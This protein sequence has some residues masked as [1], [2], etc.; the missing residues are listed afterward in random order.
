MSSVIQRLAVPKLRKTAKNRDRLRPLDE[1]DNVVA[2][3]NL[4]QRLMK[5]ADSGRLPPRR[6][7]VLAQV[8][9]AIEILL[10]AP[11]R[12][13]NL[14][15]L[16]IDRHLVRPGRARGLLH[17]VVEEHEVKNTVCLDH[18]L[19][20][21]SVGL[22]EHYLERHWPLLAAGGSRALFPG[23]GTGPKAKGTLRAQI[24]K[25]VFQFTG[26][27]V[28]P[29]LFR[30]AG[31]KLHLDLHPGEYAVV[32]RVLGHRSMDTTTNYYTGFEGKSAAR[33]YDKTMLELRKQPA[34]G[35][36]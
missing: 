9:V 26:L 14:T 34:R 23:Q 2:L 25:A 18:P 17:I 8:A 33:H 32:Q 30:H 27:R 36:S 1:P 6:A 3:E 15:A 10:M 35:R 29:H 24:Q 28:H 20:E 21:Q 12:L 13:G 5:E 31:A 16:D 22:I 11:M 19:P 7:A 4:P